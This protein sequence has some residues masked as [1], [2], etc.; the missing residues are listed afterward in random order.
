[1]GRSIPLVE[2]E[3]VAGF[4]Q[5]TEWAGLIAS[6]FFF[7]KV[8][9]GLFIMSVFL[10][11]RLGMLIGLLIVLCGKGGAHMLYLGRPLRFWRA[12]SRPG[13]SWVSRGIWAMSLMLAAGFI[14]ISLPPGSPLFMPLAIFAVICAFVVAV[15]DGF[16]LTSSPA[17]PIWNTALMPVMCMFYAL[18]GGTTMV[19]F[20]KH[21]GFIQ[22]SGKF[23]A[24]LPSV[25]ITLLVVNLLIVLLFLVG[26]INTGS[27][28]RESFD[29]L[30]KGP[31]AVPFFALVIGVGLVFTLLMSF[32]AGPRAGAGTV[33]L[34]T[35]AD[36]IGH[37]FIFFLLL[38]VGVFKPVLGF[39]K[40]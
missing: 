31:Y 27:A 1:M 13:S 24:L 30:V 38:K 37:Y 20:L 34:I 11:S 5:Q 7:G 19:L 21:L 23:T 12:M 35:V 14:A 15:Y 4:R 6:A 17:I 16:L 22:L 32:V 25:E 26:S 28:G 40:I 8:G 36:L 39:L 9:S 10:Q 18:L 33:A 29:L 3:F 2:K